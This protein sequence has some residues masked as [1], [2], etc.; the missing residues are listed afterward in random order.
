MRFLSTSEVIEL[1]KMLIAQFGGL[2]GTRDKGLLESALS[3]PQ[4]L[5]SIGMERDV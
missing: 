2:C 3:Y 4:L 1:H 5:F